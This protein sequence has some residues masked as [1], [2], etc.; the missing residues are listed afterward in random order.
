MR[1]S[2]IMVFLV[3]SKINMSLEGQ[4][5]FFFC[6][7]DSLCGLICPPGA[8]WELNGCVKRDVTIAKWRSGDANVFSV[9]FDCFSK[10]TDMNFH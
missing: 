5:C 9:R 4:K 1:F 6:N 10:H 8:L 2:E 3:A 7:C